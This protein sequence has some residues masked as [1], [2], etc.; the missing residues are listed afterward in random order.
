MYLVIILLVLI[1]V[2][3]F[4]NSSQIELVNENKVVNNQ[5]MDL[6]VKIFERLFFE[7]T[8]LLPKRFLG[9]ILYIYSIFLFIV[10]NN[11]YGLLPYSLSLTAH[12]A[13]TLFFS[14]VL[15]LIVCFNSIMLHKFSVLQLFLPAG[16]P[17]FIIALL[18]PI[19]FISFFARL[20]SLAVRLFANITAGHTLIEI[21]SS[22]IVSLF[23]FSGY[24]LYIGSGVVML[25]FC[26]IILES[27]IAL[28]Q[29]Y[30]FIMLICLYFKDIVTVH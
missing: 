16:T 18:V 6:N 19:E 11:M 4:V 9:L 30:V 21:F 26:I 20:I 8:T 22:F 5:I 13:I 15:F 3:Y 2:P 10:L 29:A 12:L 28:L 27:F 14:L 1:A 17:L 24:G 23:I 25:V 7:A